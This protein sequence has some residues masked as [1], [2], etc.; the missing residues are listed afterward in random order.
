MSAQHTQGLLAINPIELDQIAAADT[1]KEVARATQFGHSVDT[2]IA[3]ARRLAA[4]WNACDGISTDDLEQYYGC[5]GGI[6]AALEE[7]SLQDHLSAV[8]Q[9]NELLEALELAHL[10]LSGANMNR[11]VVNRKVLSAIAKAKGGSA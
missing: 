6:D 5:Q 9:R 4:C 1:S 7:A 3:N 11:D 2:I 10:L 8:V